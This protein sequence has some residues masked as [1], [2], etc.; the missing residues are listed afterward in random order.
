MLVHRMLAAYEGPGSVITILAIQQAVCHD[1]GIPTAEMVSLRRA[2]AVAR[3]RQVAMYLARQMTHNSLPAIGQRFG[4]RDH[5]TIMHGIGR[6]ACLM[7]SD[8]LFRER[9]QRIRAFILSASSPFP[10]V[11]DEDFLTL[12]DEAAAED[13]PPAVWPLKVTR[14][15]DDGRAEVVRG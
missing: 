3:P 5:T 12:F 1:Y 6:V 14:V 9:V 11:A 4:D 15:A 13:A 10:Y 2:R 8:A 7:V